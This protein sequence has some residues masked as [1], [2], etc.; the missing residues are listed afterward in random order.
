MEDA[1]LFLKERN[2]LLLLLLLLVF[3]CRLFTIQD[4]P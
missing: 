4:K 1:F 3:T 2:L